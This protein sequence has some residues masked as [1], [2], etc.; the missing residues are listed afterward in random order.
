M[1]NPNTLYPN[2]IYPNIEVQACAQ[3]CQPTRHSIHSINLNLHTVC[4]CQISI[5]HILYNISIYQYITLYTLYHI[6]YGICDYTLSEY[7][8]PGLHACMPVYALR[9][10]S[11]GGAR[12]IISYVICYMLYVIC[13]MLYVIYHI[14]YHM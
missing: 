7:R 6:S 2:I 13:Y 3:S 10:A 14:Q 4:I 8:G 1:H 9:A 11:L 5:Y 12:F